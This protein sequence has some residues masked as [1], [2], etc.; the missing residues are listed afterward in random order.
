MLKNGKICNFLPSRAPRDATRAPLAASRGYAFLHFKNFRTPSSSLRFVRYDARVM[1]D[2]FMHRARDVSQ[3]YRLKSGLRC[4]FS[5][6][7]T[8]LCCKNVAQRARLP[9]ID[10]ETVETTRAPYC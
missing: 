3:S 5:T 2:K 4:F 8:N 6:R 9:A 1:Y 10:H 7:V